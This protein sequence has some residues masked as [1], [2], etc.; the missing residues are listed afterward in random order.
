MDTYYIVKKC[1]QG[2]ETP[3]VIPCKHGQRIIVVQRCQPR[4]FFSHNPVTTTCDYFHA[5]CK[6]KIKNIIKDM[7][8]SKNKK[9]HVKAI[10]RKQ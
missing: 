3:G 2:E 7:K 8:I 9:K 4:R 6:I 1:W 10:T 5:S